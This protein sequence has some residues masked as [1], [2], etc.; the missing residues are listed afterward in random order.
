[1]LQYCRHLPGILIEYVTRLETKLEEQSEVA[2]IVFVRSH[3]FLLRIFSISLW[4][5]QSARHAVRDLQYVIH[6]AVDLHA[7]TFL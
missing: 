6:G 5:I 4:Q 1:M 7:L 3:S 2:Q